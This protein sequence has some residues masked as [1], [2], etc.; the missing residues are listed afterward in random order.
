M[1]IPSKPPIGYHKSGAGYVRVYNSLASA[2][3]AHERLMDKG[4]TSA[5]VVYQGG[6][7]YAVMFQESDV[8]AKGNP[9]VP[10]G[11]FLP[12]RLNPDGT[13]TFKVP[14]KKRTSVKRKPAKRVKR[15]ARKKNAKRKTAKRKR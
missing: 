14:S 9:G 8:R 10:V 12:A 13:V 1:A 5:G 3:K 6:T 4:Y 15:V 2:Q 7:R 11:K